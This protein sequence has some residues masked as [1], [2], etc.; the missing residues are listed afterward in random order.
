MA[1]YAAYLALLMARQSVACRPTSRLGEMEARLA[2]GFA[3]TTQKARR[4]LS[5]V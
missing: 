4:R 2:A 3:A 5:T 1:L